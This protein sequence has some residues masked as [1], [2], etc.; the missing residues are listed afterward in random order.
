MSETFPAIGHR[1]LV[2]FQKFRV[3]LYFKSE[4]LLAV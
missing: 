3:E 1:Y 2:D 4:T